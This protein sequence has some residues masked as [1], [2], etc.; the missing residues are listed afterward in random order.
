ME[1]DLNQMHSQAE[2][3]IREHHPPGNALQDYRP[4]VKGNYGKF[5]QKNK[6]K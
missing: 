1:A 4:L 3:T 5:Y 2:K 6:K